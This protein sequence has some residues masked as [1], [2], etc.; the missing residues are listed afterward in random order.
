MMVTVPARLVNLLREALVTRLARAAER[1]ASDGCSSPAAGIDWQ[2]L[3][4]FDAYRALLESIGAER[5]ATKEHVEVDLSV[6]RWALESALHERLAT[7]RLLAATKRRSPASPGG[8]PLHKWVK[9]NAE[10]IEAF[11]ASLGE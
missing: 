11:M 2:L 10:E 5:T 9:A 7:E 8:L 6:H 3:E 1:F 4:P